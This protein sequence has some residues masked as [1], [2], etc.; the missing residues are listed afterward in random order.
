M[1]KIECAREE[2]VLE[3]LNADRWPADCGD[4][5][6]AHVASCAVCG[7]LADAASAIFEDREE[8]L[9]E[10]ELPGS[11]IV[12][13]RMQLRARNEAAREARKTIATVQGLAVA[14]AVIVAITLLNFMTP[15]WL[16]SVKD[17]VTIDLTTLV[18]VPLLVLALIAWLALTPIA[19]WLLFSG[20][21]RSSRR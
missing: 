5:L 16:G 20:A 13:W 10:A 14:V 15:G 11:G 7:D 21:S 17:A 8:L 1:T 6:R 2:E 12:W 4:E 18:G 9:R 3:L 19:A